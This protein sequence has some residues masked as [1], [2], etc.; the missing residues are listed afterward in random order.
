[1]SKILVRATFK[2]HDG[3]LNE[4]KSLAGQAMSAVKA[5]EPGNLQYDWYFNEDNTECVVHETYADSNAVFAHAGNVGELL[6]KLGQVSDL[7]LEVYGDV[8]QELKKV[9]ADMK[10]KLYSFYQGK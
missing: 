4:F 6:G 8:S 1:M 3:K 9:I 7:L 10:G 2:I 5:N